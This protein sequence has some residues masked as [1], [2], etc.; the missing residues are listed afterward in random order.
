MKHRGTQPSACTDGL[1]PELQL[2]PVPPELPVPDYLTVAAKI[3]A[4]ARLLDPLPTIAIED[5][6]RATI[7][8]VITARCGNQLNV[9]VVTRLRAML[10]LDAST[11]KPPPSKP[12]G[13]TLKNRYTS[14]AQSV[15]GYPWHVTGKEKS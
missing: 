9:G 8:S 3:E 14:R 13:A 5:V 2:A 12:P 1:Q 7:R 15:V 10:V 11:P 6:L 4:V